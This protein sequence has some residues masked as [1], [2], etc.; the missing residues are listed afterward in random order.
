MS[1]LGVATGTIE[2]S[3]L[4]RKRFAIACQ[5]EEE[6]WA[7]LASSVKVYYRDPATGEEHDAPPVKRAPRRRR[8][9]RL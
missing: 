7:E 3:P 8:R 1:K 5:R 6:R 9:N 2:V 4:G